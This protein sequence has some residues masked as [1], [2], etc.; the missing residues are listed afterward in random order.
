MRKK[1]SEFS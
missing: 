1:E